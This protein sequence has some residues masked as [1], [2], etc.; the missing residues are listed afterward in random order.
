MHRDKSHYVRFAIIGLCVIIAAV[1][2]SFVGAVSLVGCFCVALVSFC[3]P[4]L[5]HS[6]ISGQ[7]EVFDLTLFVAGV[8]M[9]MVA[10]LYTLRT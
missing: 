4:P 7:I 5:L 1:L 9:T 6:K 3:L 2:P 8:F 10:T